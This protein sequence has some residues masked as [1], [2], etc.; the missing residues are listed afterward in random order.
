LLQSSAQEAS[1]NRRPFLFH[2]L[3]SW[4]V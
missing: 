1:H 2:C 3:P 4:G